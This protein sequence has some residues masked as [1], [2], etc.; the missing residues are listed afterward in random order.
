MPAPHPASRYK[1]ALPVPSS[2]S[3][4]AVPSKAHDN[5]E[6]ASDE[7]TSATPPSHL[8]FSTQATAGGRCV[9]T[10]N[11]AFPSNQPQEPAKKSQPVQDSRRAD[12]H[13]RPLPPQ[14]APPCT[15]LA[16]PTNSFVPSHTTLPDSPNEEQPPPLSLHLAHSAKPN[17]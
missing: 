13:L 3:N 15:S 14:F 5:H 8:Q 6:P 2:S 17:Q 1:A 4:P 7:P 12:L 11:L 10:V 9:A 16:Y